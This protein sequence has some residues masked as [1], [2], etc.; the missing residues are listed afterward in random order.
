MQITTSI[1]IQT[2]KINERK[3]SLFIYI[4]FLSQHA[5][6]W[7]LK[8]D[9]WKFAQFS[10]NSSSSYRSLS[11][12]GV[13]S[14]ISYICFLDVQKRLDVLLHIEMSLNDCL[15]TKLKWSFFSTSS[16]PPFFHV[17]IMLEIFVICLKPK[18]PMRRANTTWKRMKWKK[19]E[20]PHFISSYLFFY[21]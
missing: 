13:H 21:F 8:H 19:Q 9:I 3:F 12:P 7:E 11:F 6:L 17:C 5:L 20:K 18:I 1:H 15:S 2:R 10:M 16:L 14:F 4:H